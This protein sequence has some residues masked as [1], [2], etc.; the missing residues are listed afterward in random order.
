MSFIFHRALDVLKPI[1]SDLDSSDATSHDDINSELKSPISLVHEMVLK[2]NMTVAFKVQSEKGPPH[3]KTFITLCIVG[4]FTVR[5]FVVFFLL[6][7]N[8][9]IFLDGR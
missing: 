4:N 7:I 5:N 6:L 9:Y 1:T 8:Q 2:R 3:M